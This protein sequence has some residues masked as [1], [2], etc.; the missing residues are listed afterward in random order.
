MAAVDIV[1]AENAAESLFGNQMDG[2]EQEAGVPAANELSE[3]QI[4]GET[5]VPPANEF[6]QMSAIEDLAVLTPV[7]L[8]NILDVQAEIEAERQQECYELT[9]L[10]PVPL[11]ISASAYN[12]NGAQ[13]QLLRH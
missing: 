10:Q 6:H 5:G 4:G 12:S 11:D 3:N 13:Q 9:E 7:I 8:D 2:I 1:A